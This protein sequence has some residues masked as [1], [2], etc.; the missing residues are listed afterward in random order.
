MGGDRCGVAVGGDLLAELEDGQADGDDEREEGEL[1]GVPGLQTEHT[2]GQGDEGHSLEQD[3]DQDGDDDLLEL[4]LAGLSNGAALAELDVEAHLVVLEVA[5]ADLDGGF[6]RQL[7][8]HIVGGEEGAHGLEEGAFTGQAAT[9]HLVN[10]VR[11]AG[12]FHSLGYL[13]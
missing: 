1:Q 5:R 7:E 2:D 3:E 11:V 9:G 8:G 13:Q 10:G 4:G 12:D 6:E